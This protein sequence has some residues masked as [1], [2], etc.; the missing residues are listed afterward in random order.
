[1]AW[2]ACVPI[3]FVP[4]NMAHFH[5][6]FSGLINR[7]WVERRMTFEEKFQTF[8]WEI[9]QAIYH[10]RP[11]VVRS[12]ASCVPSQLF[13]SRTKP[14]GDNSAAITIPQRDQ[15]TEAPCDASRTA[16]GR[17]DNQLRSANVKLLSL[18]RTNA[19]VSDERKLNHRVQIPHRK[20]LDRWRGGTVPLFL[21]NGSHSKKPQRPRD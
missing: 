14:S 13:V 5:S 9:L 18:A 16:D 4:K 6:L 12:D 11:L 1:M 10:R 20:E 8:H 2:P 7:S 17:F 15:T 3:N 19:R 21:D